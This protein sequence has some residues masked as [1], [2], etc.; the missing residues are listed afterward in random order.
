MTGVASTTRLDVD[1]Y[2]A[3]RAAD[4]P[5]F[6]DGV[7]ALERTLAALDPDA[8]AAP[9]PSGEGRRG[10]AATAGAR[11]VDPPVGRRSRRRRHHADRSAPRR[12]R[13]RRVRRGHLSAQGGARR[14]RGARRHPR[15]G[16][17]RPRHGAGDHRR[18]RPDHVGDGRPQ[19]RTRDDQR[20]R[21]SILLALWGRRPLDV[22]HS[23]PLAAA[24]L[25]LGG[26]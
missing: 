15:R 9:A 14:P 13:H 21:R 16:S 17:R 4:G 24:W 26:N 25:A 10:V 8:G 12:R 22:C 5:R 3:H 20:A 1:G 19:R 18:A 23:D 11:D 2:L 6:A 7:D